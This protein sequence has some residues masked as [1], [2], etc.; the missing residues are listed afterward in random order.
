MYFHEN[1]GLTK[2]QTVITSDSTSNTVY[3][4]LTSIRKTTALNISIYD[5]ATSNTT[6]NNVLVKVT[7]PQSTDTLTAPAKTYEQTIAGNGTISISYPRWK[8]AEDKASG[9][10]IAPEVSITYAQSADVITW[11]ACANADNEAQNYA[12]LSDDFKIKKTIQNS[13]YNIS[14]YGKSTRIEIPSVSG[15]YGTT[16]DP[17]SDGK[18]I[19]MMAKDS[20]GNFTIDCGETTTF[21]QTIG[22]S[23]TQTHGNFNGLGNGVFIND[24]TYTEKYTTIEVKFFADGTDTGIVKQLRSDTGNYS[25]TL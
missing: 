25:F 12:F 13:S 4:E 5:A 20:A 6:A 2:D 16:S 14:L 21:A 10:E 9:I 18:I 23:G 7:V 24:T 15:T 8:N 17:A 22:T 3:A 19:R 1:Y 11:K